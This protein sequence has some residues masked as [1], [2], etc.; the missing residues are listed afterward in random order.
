MPEYAVIT[1]TG[2]LGIFSPN[3]VTGTGLL[4]I[5]SPNMVYRSCFC[6]DKKVLVLAPLWGATKKASLPLLI[7]K[8]GDGYKQIVFEGTNQTNEEWSV[9]SPVLAGT[10]VDQ[11][12]SELRQLSDDSFLWSP[13]NS[14]IDYREFT[15]DEWQK[16]RLGVN[17]YQITATFRSTNPK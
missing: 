16:I 5:F 9:T 3:M 6:P 4:G 15:C 13:S 8:L 14:E 17:Q 7:N 11:V 12:L 10:Q 1:G 2:L